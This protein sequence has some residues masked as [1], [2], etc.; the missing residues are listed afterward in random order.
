MFTKTNKWLKTLVGEIGSYLYIRFVYRHWSR[1]YR[2][3]WE[4]KYRNYL[5]HP[6]ESIQDLAKAINN[7]KWKAD[8]WKQL[9]DAF[10]YPG[11]VQSVLDNGGGYIG[12]CDEFA[13]Y[14][15]TVINNGIM[16]AY[17]KP[18]GNL[19]PVYAY[20]LTVTWIDE[21]GEY[22]GHNVCLIKSFDQKRRQYFYSYMDYGLP[23]PEM[24]SIGEVVEQVLSNYG[25]NATLLAWA[26]H[27]PELEMVKAH[28]GS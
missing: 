2:L 7:M 22:G 19:R 9:W 5:L 15:A 13:C 4:F 28:M 12:D 8:D 6:Y 20:I 11:T 10:S 1:L 21:D 26:M 17:L 23:N 25:E 27:T 18:F 24:K 14:E 16:G 3:I